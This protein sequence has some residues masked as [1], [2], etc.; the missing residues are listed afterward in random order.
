MD[1]TQFNKK[2]ESRSGLQSACRTCHKDARHKHDADYYHRKSADPEFMEEQRRRSKEWY[3][4]NRQ[5]AADHF[6]EKNTDP[7]FRE[8]R[9]RRRKKWKMANPDKLRASQYKYT[10]ID[11]TPEEYHQKVAKQHNLCALCGNPPKG[12][13]NGCNSSLHTD[14][15]H[16]TGKTRDLLCSRCNRALGLLYDDPILLAKAAEYVTKHRSLAVGA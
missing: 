4:A 7:E 12:P 9:A 13:G 16:T 8:D 15:D 11:S 1:P 3:A 5:H 10:G 2:T 6:Q 14:H